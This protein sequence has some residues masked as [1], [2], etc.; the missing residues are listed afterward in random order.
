MTQQ[1]D[2]VTQNFERLAQIWS[3]KSVPSDTEKFQ[4]KKFLL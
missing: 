4:Q 3:N 1:F 2:V